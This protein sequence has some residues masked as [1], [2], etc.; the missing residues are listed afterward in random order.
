MGSR[1]TRPAT[2]ITGSV[3]EKPIDA[4]IQGDSEAT[5][6]PSSS[7]TSVAVAVTRARSD[8]IGSPAS[9]NTPAVAPTAT[10]AIHDD[11]MT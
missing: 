7:P 5:S 6:R 9:A 8:M 11:P 2:N 10:I 1:P 4:T 3:T